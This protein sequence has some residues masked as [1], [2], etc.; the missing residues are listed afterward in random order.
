MKRMI[1]LALS[2]ALSLCACSTSSQIPTLGE[3]VENGAEIEHI[4]VTS[5]EEGSSADDEQQTAPAVQVTQL[6]GSDFELSAEDA[7]TVLQILDTGSWIPDAN[8]CDSDYVVT[9]Q[10]R[11][12]YYHSDCG[13]FNEQLEQSN[14]SLRLSDA[15]RETV[16]RI[17]QAAI[18]HDLAPNAPL[19]MIDTDV[20]P[21]NTYT[22][23]LP[24]PPG[25]VSWAA[26]NEESQDCA[27]NLTDMS[28]TDYAEYM[29]LLQQ[30]GFSV[31]EEISENIEGQKYNSINTLLSS[32]KKNISIN[33]IP[34][35]FTI[36]ISFV[37]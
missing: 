9:L 1:A 28:D 37:E 2:L 26:F 19:T 11:T 32:E 7:E 22:D 29:G 16:N 25:T 23:G 8:K 6:G 4:T 34:G 18:S 15:E 14:Q 31:V 33:Y 10:G 27:V 20:W 24:V 30:A 35:S 17:I 5:L 36:Y 12:L 3:I 13:T 21:E